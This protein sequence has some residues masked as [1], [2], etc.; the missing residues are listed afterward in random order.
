[1]RG[2]RFPRAAIF[3]MLLILLSTVAAI[4]MGRN[5]SEAYPGNVPLDSAWPGVFRV[6]ALMPVMFCFLGAL[7]YFV[8]YVLRQSGVQRFPNLQTWTQRR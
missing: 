3:L 6:F 1:M 8:L 2:F 4:E 5:I 7:G